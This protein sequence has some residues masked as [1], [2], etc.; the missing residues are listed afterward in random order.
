MFNSS[1]SLGAFT[2]EDWDHPLL[3]R[4]REE[5]D[6]EKVDWIIH[7]KLMLPNG[8]LNTSGYVQTG[9]LRIDNLNTIEGVKYA[10]DRITGQ[11]ATAAEPSWYLAEFESDSTP[12]TDWTGDFGDTVAG[13]C[14]EF[15]DYDEAARQ[16]C[17]F[18]AA[19][20]TTRVTA[21]NP[22]RAQITVS[23]GVSNKSIYGICLTNNST[24]EYDGGS[25]I[26]LAATRYPAVRTYNAAE[27][28]YLGYEIYTP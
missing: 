7:N 14:T 19:T 10:F 17:V 16:E 21:T 1:T 18:T 4:A 2:A 6:P 11:A 9:S 28:K 27:V 15:T 22:T 26:L 20:G 13:D 25:A 23:T 3:L 24:K 8:R 12:A 5:G